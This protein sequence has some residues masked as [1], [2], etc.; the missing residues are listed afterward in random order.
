MR[1]ATRGLGTALA[2]VMAI[3]PL[4]G[5]LHYSSVRHLAC[6]EDGELVE[7]PLQSAHAHARTA[8]GSALFPEAPVAPQDPAAGHDHCTIA[9]Y[10]RAGVGVSQSQ[11]R[12]SFA[13]GAFLRPADPPEPSRAPGVAL[14]RLVPKASPP[15]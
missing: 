9:S 6:P 7:V 1:F 2:A 11:A 3:S 5:T 15:A 14:Y 13:P 12:S 4:L 10:R 8:A